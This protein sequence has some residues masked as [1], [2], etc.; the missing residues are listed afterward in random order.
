MEWLITGAAGF[1]GRHVVSEALDQGKRVRAIVRPTSDL[2]GIQWI[3][4]PAVRVER[5]DLRSPA[6]LPN[7]LSGV[8]VVIHLAGLKQGDLKAQISGTVAPT[9]RLLEAMVEAG[10]RRMV[11]VSSLSVYDFRKIA[12]FGQL[13]EDSPLESQPG[14]REPYC[15]AKLLQEHVVRRYGEKHGLD[16]TILRP[17]VVIGPG[18]TWTD[19]LGIRLNRWLWLRF[20]AKG[21]PMQL[22]YVENCASAIVLAAESDAAIGQTFN[23]VDEELPTR[24]H[25]M[26]ELRRRLPSRPFVLPLSGSLMRLLAEKALKLNKTLSD[27]RARLPWIADPARLETQLK[28][29][30]FSND[31]IKRVLGWHPRF[32]LGEALDRCTGRR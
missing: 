11:L 17:G 27:G 29:L 16:T 24:R 10:A 5:C 28:P 30:K 12:C 13:D 22:T 1:I 7:L 21:M 9:E 2:S 23:V 6:E 18:N 3:P 14:E 25:Y 4:H 26:A 15:Q 31:R 19:Q 32:G 8:D 20:S